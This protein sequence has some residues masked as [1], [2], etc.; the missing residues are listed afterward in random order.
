MSL[1]FNIYLLI[2]IDFIV[3]YNYDYCQVMK[4]NE[5]ALPENGQLS[6]N[7]KLEANEHIHGIHADSPMTSQR[8]LDLAVEMNLISLNT[9]QCFA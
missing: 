1:R 3:V 8:L 7:E 5:M 4:L 9:F 2:F 6:D